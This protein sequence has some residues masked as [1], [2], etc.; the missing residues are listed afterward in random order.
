MGVNRIGA[1][2]SLPLALAAGLGLAPMAR[3][4]SGVVATGGEIPERQLY[5]YLVEVNSVS[6]FGVSPCPC[7]WP[8]SG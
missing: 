4:V 1:I 7:Y 8:A 2:C 5:V 6:V 3:C